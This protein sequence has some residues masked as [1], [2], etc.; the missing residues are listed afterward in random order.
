M[1][2]KILER[3]KDYH[4]PRGVALYWSSMLNESDRDELFLA[5]DRAIAR[6]LERMT[7]EE[8]KAFTHEHLMRNDDPTD[9]LEFVIKESMK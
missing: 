8:L 9:Q 3:T 7:H 1:I 2:E 6:A 4:S 5:Y